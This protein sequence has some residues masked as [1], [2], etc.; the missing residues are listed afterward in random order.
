MVSQ[1]T[2]DWL[3]E[4]S[5]NRQNEYDFPRA[6]NVP[7]SLFYLALAR[8]V[9]GSATGIEVR[10]LEAKDSPL[11]TY[12]DKSATCVSDG[13]ERLVCY[14]VH[15]G[16]IECAFSREAVRHLEGHVI[17]SILKDRTPDRY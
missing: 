13:H 1:S 10:T 17:L 2:L 15:Y 5:R 14:R 12:G 16:D 6:G 4:D 11:N 8:V 7:A 9:E 3:A